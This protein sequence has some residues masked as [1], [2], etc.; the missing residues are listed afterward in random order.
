MVLIPHSISPP[1]LHHKMVTESLLSS[2]PMTLPAKPTTPAEIRGIIYKVGQ[3]EISRPRY[4][5]QQ[6]NQ[7]PT[8]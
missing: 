2:L 5:N 4:Y 1:P 3:Q 7:K 8:G 6:S